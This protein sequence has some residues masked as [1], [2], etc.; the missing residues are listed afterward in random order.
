LDVKVKSGGIIMVKK[1]VAFLLALSMLFIFA[2]CKA[3]ENGS[4]SLT[5]KE[6]ILRV[7]MD[8]Q[9]PPFETFDADNNPS[10][11]SVDVAQG[12]AD[13]LGLELEVVN[14][15]FSTLI[16]A[17]EI[18][19]IDIAIASMSINKER[20]KKVD[21]TKPYFYFRIIGLLNKDF[22]SEHNLNDS[23]SADDLWAVSETKFVGIAAQISTSIPESKGFK[24]EEAIDKASAITEVSQGRADVLIMSPEVVV[25]A[26]N[27]YPDTTQIF[28]SE[29]DVSG[30]G[31]AVTEGNSAL[32]AE[33]NT[34]ID[35]LDDEGGIYDMLREKYQPYLD[36]VYGGGV[37]M[38]IYIYE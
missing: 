10:G 25:G 17:L 4:L 35:T 15:D 31:M 34:Y 36:G 24:V 12:L 8:L 33:A 3:K 16:P 5:V 2:S 13:M 23:S 30:I 11:I 6:G 21:F 1:Y 9:Y 18:G 19:D 22:A 14:M 26:N 38:D 27:A 7:G 20:E 29:L 37:T 32:L 28:W